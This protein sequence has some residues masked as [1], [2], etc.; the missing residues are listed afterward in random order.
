MPM[1]G[2]KQPTRFVILTKHKSMEKQSLTNLGIATLIANLYALPP[3][4]LKL[5]IDAMALDFD[6]WV[7][8]H[9]YLNASQEE[10]LLQ[11]P[12]A[13]KSN[14]KRKL[15]NNL[16]KGSPIVFTK[17]EPSDSD[18]KDREGRGKLFGINQEST[19]SYS[20]TLGIV[21]DETLYISINY[22]K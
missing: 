17:V 18:D 7:I 12:I 13:F 5:E 10:Y 21:T 2:P 3:E 9:I 4:E 14:L 6:S 19:S 1:Q 22:S 16:A 20:T 15:I 8:N 11:L